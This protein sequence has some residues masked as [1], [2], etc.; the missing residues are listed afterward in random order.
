MSNNIDDIATILVNTDGLAEKRR[1]A[2]AVKLRNWAFIALIVAVVVT[3]AAAGF[4]GFQAADASARL[5]ALEDKQAVSSQEI[6]DAEKRIVELEALVA[7]RDKTIASQEAL[8]ASREGFIAVV[9]SAAPLIE[10][11]LTKVDPAALIKV[12]DEQQNRVEKERSDPKVIAD[13]TSRVQVA[14]DALRALVDEFDQQEKEREQMEQSISREPAPAP[15]SPDDAT[16]GGARLALNAVGGEWV[17]LGRADVVCDLAAAIACAHP[18]GT[19]MVANRVA[20]NNRDYWMGP[21]AH[22]YAHQMQFKNWEAILASPTMAALFTA[23]VPGI[24]R[25]ADCMA[26]TIVPTWSGPYQASCTADQLAYA[27]RVWTGNA[28]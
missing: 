23:D 20:G 10:E 7:E 15:A 13:A 2:R 1:A 11:A 14:M 25:L 19:V 28:A 17:K 21:M 27:Q 16:L 3:V 18:D 26:K 6:G 4:F 8:L 9:Q 24:E 5:T 22:E 12:V